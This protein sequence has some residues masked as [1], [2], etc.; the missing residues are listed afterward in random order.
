MKTRI[1]RK[2]YLPDA[3]VSCALFQENNKDHFLDLLDIDSGIMTALS[4]VAK[5]IR[6]NG[7]FNC[8]STN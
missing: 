5:F 1:E 8:K 2:Q 3:R 6:R 7:R 4:E